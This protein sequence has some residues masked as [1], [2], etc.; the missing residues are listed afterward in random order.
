MP[1]QF[2]PAHA[3]LFVGAIAAL[4]LAAAPPAAV[5]QT[6]GSGKTYDEILDTYV[7]DGLVYYRALKA[8]RA[9]LGDL[10]IAVVGSTVD[11]MAPATVQKIL[12]TIKQAEESF[13]CSVGLVIF[14][15][16]AKLI[17]AGETRAADLRRRS[18]PTACR[19]GTA[20][21]GRAACPRRGSPRSRRPPSR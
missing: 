9:K 11:L 1:R 16:F 19:R 14:D 6:H 15:T 21:R 8:E 18:P 12:A 3:G 10:P 17:A 20:G 7:R 2:R 13:G 4:W 5:G